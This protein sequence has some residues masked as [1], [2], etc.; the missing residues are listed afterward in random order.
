M[1]LLVITAIGLFRMAVL[2]DDLAR[3][4]ERR[5]EAVLA[6]V[7]VAVDLER[8]I[9][10]GP[11]VGRAGDEAQRASAVDSWRDRCEECAATAG[12][13]VEGGPAGVV[14][15]SFSS[16]GGE[17]RLARGEV[18]GVRFSGEMGR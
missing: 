16:F 12:G 7:G 14:V 6:L 4:H 5:T 3:R 10:G 1:I 13:T 9:A 8:C 15:V 2:T 11:R 18:V 17:V